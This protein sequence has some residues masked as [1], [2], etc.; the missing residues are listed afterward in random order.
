MS[1]QLPGTGGLTCPACEQKI[2][3]P[4]VNYGHPFRCSSCSIWLRVP[5]GYNRRYGTIHLLGAAALCW[6]LG[7]RGWRLVPA[8]VG[9]FFVLAFSLSFIVRRVDPP[10]LEQ[11]P[12]T[13]E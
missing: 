4:S 9:T 3:W 8:I 2:A 7:I 10:A 6:F 5:P 13:N 12:Y 1:I 11:S